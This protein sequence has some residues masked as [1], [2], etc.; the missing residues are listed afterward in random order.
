M[1]DM[2]QYTFMQRALLAALLIGVLCSIISV[3]VVLKKMSF[4]GVGVSHSAFGGVALGFWTGVNP[5]AVA[6]PFALAT[7]MAIGLVSRRG[8]VTEDVA[9]GIFYAAAM[10]LGILFIGLSTGYNVD[11]FGYLFGSILAVSTSDLWL[12]GL[13]GLGVLLV[14][15]LFF[16]ELFFLSFDEEMAR[17]NGLPVELLYYLLLGMMAITVV[18]AIKIVGII[19]VSALLVIPGATAFQITRNFRLMMLLSVLVGVVCGVVGLVLSYQFDLAPGATIVLTATGLFLICLI[20]S[21]RRR[22]KT[23]RA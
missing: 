1:I 19:L 5:I 8:R 10:A 3:Y 21:P 6:I 4:I 14:V 17:V 11:L 9:I 12:I 22:R 18:V 2:F 7:A 15:L 13:L 20:F 23:R 16:K